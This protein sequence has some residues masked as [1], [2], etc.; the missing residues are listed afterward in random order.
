MFIILVV[1]G[2]EYMLKVKAL[3]AYNSL[4]LIIISNSYAKVVANRTKIYYFKFAIKLL[5]KR[6]NNGFTAD[7]FNIIYID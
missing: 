6:V 4:Q 7:N 1:K 3:L 2:L 5:F